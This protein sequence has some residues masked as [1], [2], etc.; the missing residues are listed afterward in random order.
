MITPREINTC[1]GL[2]YPLIDPMFTQHFKPDK[3]QYN[4]NALLQVIKFTDRTTK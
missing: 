2:I 4:R 1:I 3:D